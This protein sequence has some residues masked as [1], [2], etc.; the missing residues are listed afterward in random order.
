MGHFDGGQLG[1][2]GRG[3]QGSHGSGQGLF[4]RVKVGLRHAQRLACGIGR[5]HQ[6][7]DFA[8][9]GCFA[10]G[11]GGGRA[12]HVGGGCGH[13][14]VQAGEVGRC[15]FG[16]GSGG[17][18]RVHGGLGVGDGGGEGGGSGGERGLGSFYGGQLGGCGRGPQGSHGGG[19]G[20]FGRVKVGLRQAQ[21][22][23]CGQGG[24]HQ[25]A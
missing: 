13:G 4:G 9:G 16:C 21:L 18:G 11:G 2:C 22:L 5:L 15:F 17:V 24:E 6:G 25:E 20:L 8:V 19:Q 3:P 10:G 1:G 7:G 14:G 12:L 23:F